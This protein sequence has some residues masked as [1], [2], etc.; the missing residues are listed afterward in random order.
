MSEA[1]DAAER[2]CEAVW[3]RAYQENPDY[4]NEVFEEWVRM[5][6]PEARP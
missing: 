5:Y 6:H 4:Y 3:E 1:T 2:L